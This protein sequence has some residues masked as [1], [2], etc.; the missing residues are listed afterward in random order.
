MFRVIGKGGPDGNAR[1]ESDSVLTPAD[2][3][4]IA[5][6]LG[7]R[8]IR[9]RKIG[10]V[11]AR[12]ATKREV[13]ETHSDG[14]ETINTARVG[15]FIV[16]NLSPRREPLR[17]RDGE[18]NIYVIVAERFPALYEPTGDESTHGAV[19]RAKG[20]VSAIRLPGGFDIAAPWGERQTAPSG[21]LLCNGREVYGA[22]RS[23]F[24]ATYAVEAPI[25]QR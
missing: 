11:A 17:D 23:D 3:E 22:S 18:L 10:Y 7:N 2:F 8:P 24:E 20:V 4:R 21:Y 1:V 14:K 6:D 19:H 5:A 9:A 13:V 16:T 12:K 15:D 25:D